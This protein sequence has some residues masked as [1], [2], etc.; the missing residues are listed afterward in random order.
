MI[1]MSVLDISSLDKNDIGMDVTLL[2][3]TDI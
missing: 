1:G 2:V 3:F